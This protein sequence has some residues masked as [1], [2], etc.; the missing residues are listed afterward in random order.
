MHGWLVCGGLVLLGGLEFPALVGLW[1][2]CG[3]LVILV[4][5]LPRRWC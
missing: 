4:F 3:G 1:Y 2:V 5:A